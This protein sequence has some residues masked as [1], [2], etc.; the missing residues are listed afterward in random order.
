MQKSCKVSF[1]L[2]VVDQTLTSIRISKRLW[3]AFADELANEGTDAQVHTLA[4]PHPA[5]LHVLDLVDAEKCAVFFLIRIY[6]P[7]ASE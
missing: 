1:G 3:K 5:L 6:Y 7:H 2:L 4:N